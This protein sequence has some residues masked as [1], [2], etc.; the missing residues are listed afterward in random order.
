MSDPSAR[1]IRLALANEVHPGTVPALPSSGAGVATLTAEDGVQT[2]ATGASGGGGIVASAAAVNTGASTTKPASAFPYTVPTGKRGV[3]RMSAYVGPA[4]P[5]G[6]GQVAVNAVWPPF[7]DGSGNLTLAQPGDGGTYQLGTML[8][9]EGSSVSP[10]Q[11]LV[12]WAEEGQTID[13]ELVTSFTGG[14]WAWGV[15]LEA[16]AVES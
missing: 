7:P 2:W 6:S 14:D 4:S 10:G 15:C 11:E 3:Y 16:L 1:E 13:Y 5:A 12:W 8:I 9:G